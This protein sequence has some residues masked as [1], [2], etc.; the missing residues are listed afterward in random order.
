MIRPIMTPTPTP[1]PNA[2]RL[3]AEESRR[4]KRE[5]AQKRREMRDFRRNVQER[6]ALK[7]PLLGPQDRQPTNVLAERR[8][9][10]MV[11]D[12]RKVQER[13]H[14]QKQE[15]KLRRHKAEVQ[16]RV[17][18]PLRTAEAQSLHEQAAEQRARQLQEAQ[19]L[20][21]EM[22]NRAAAEAKPSET[23]LAAKRYNK[24][25]RAALTDKIA[26]LPNELPPLSP[27]G[28]TLAPPTGED[29]PM[30]W[31]VNGWCEPAANC[32]F[33]NDM[34][35]HDALLRQMVSQWAD[36]RPTH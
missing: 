18:Q 6:L 4:T 31:G 15:E 12:R 3:A 7:E 34:A 19:L 30:C 21:A 16:H 35:G 27:S 29:V 32:P 17:E 33:K 28:C 2:A 13:V 11:R 1:T 36:G 8:R 26:T 20:Q 9:N 25:V 24:A 10:E 14:Q 5:M 23:K 22:W